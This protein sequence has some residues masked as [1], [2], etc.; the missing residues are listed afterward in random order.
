METEKI[1]NTIDV[2]QTKDHK[3]K[4]KSYVKKYNEEYY[5]QNKERNLQHMAEKIECDI[6]KCTIARSSTSEHF[7]TNKHRKNLDKK[8]NIFISETKKTPDKI[9]MIN[10]NTIK[11]SKDSIFTEVI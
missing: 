6:C 9:F 8:V 2:F 1:D 4:T 5:K 7:R 3:S 10:Y 11:C